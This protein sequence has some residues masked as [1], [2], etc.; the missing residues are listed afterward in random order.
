MTSSRPYRAALP[1]ATAIAH[2]A[3]AA[4]TQFDPRL[5]AAFVRHCRM[6]AGGLASSL[7]RRSLLVVNLGILY[8]RASTE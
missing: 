2:I 8:T 3:A 6:A 5:A 1:M 7:P 4:C